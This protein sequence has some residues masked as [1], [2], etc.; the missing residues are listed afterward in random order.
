MRDFMKNGAL[1]YMANDF[2]VEASVNVAQ[3]NIKEA[4]VAMDRGKA[5]SFATAIENRHIVR[6]TPVFMEGEAVAA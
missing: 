6:K 2:L 1:G 3:T 4:F 5:R